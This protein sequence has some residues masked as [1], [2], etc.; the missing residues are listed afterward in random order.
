MNRFP[1]IFGE[2]RGLHDQKLKALLVTHG[3]PVAYVR[4]TSKKDGMASIK[5]DDA[6]NLFNGYLLVNLE[7]ALN[8]IRTRIRKRVEELSEK[9]R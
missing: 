5:L 8:D 7:V 9:E 2:D 4:E 3:V 1:L 6:N